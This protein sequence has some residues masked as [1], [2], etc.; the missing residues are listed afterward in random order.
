[1]NPMGVYYMGWDPA[2]APDF[3]AYCVVRQVQYDRDG[4]SYYQIVALDRFAVGTPYP[5]QSDTIRML[6]AGVTQRA[7]QHRRDQLLPGITPPPQLV[8]DS[9]G[10][11]RAVVDM[12]RERGLKPVALEITAGM[13]VTQGQGCL[14]VPK[15]QLVSVGQ[16]QLQT[17][18]L[19]ISNKLRHART[20]VDELLRF[21]VKIDPITAHDSYGT[22][23]EGE[24][25]DLVLAVLLALWWA[26]WEAKAGRR[27]DPKAW[28]PIHTWA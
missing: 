3:S 18:R 19:Q 10:V 2:L 16:V 14:R 22:W 27:L 7:T 12:A 5:R 8:M 6:M 11:G 4:P 21:K 1:M 20:L 15:R 24:H 25:D 26:E 13:D 9:T 23:R 17:D 28:K